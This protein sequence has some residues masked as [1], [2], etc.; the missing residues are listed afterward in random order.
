MNAKNPIIWADYPDPDVI[1]VDNTYYMVSTSMHMFPGGQILSSLDLVHWEHSCYVFDSL[2]D[3]QAQRL[4]GG[5]IYGKGMWA[6][7][8]RHHNGLFHLM[9]ACNDTHKSYRFTSEKA[10]GP[11]TRHEIQ[12]FYHDCSLLFDDDGRVYIAHGYKEIRITEL[13][14]DLSGPKEGGLQRVA[15]TDTGDVRVCFEGTHFYK[16]DGKYYLFCIHWPNDGYARRTEVCY[17]AD[18]LTSAFTGKTIVDDDL[19]FHNM[20]I[21][22]GALVDTPQGHWYLMLFQDHGAV[23]RSPVLVP[24]TWKNSFPSVANIPEQFAVDSPSLKHSHK[25]LHASDTLRKMPL[26]P[27]WQWNH[28]SHNSLWSVTENGLRMMTDRTVSCLEKAVNILTQRTF[29]PE[30]QATVTVDASQMH[31]GDYAGLCALQGC[32]CQ[33]AVTH[34]TDGLYL[35]FISREAASHN[36]FSST[37]PVCERVRIKHDQH[38]VK[39]KACFRFDD[40]ADSVSFFY[41][42]QECWLPVGKPHALVYRLDHFMGCRIGL[43]CYATKQPGGSAVFSDFEYMVSP[44]CLCPG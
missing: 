15:I 35:S 38:L 25:P 9:F 10:H 29:G 17:M 20:G 7:S 41:L 8:L 31:I 21:A 2:G 33:L 30:C 11:W 4:N 22:Q 13:E 12:G 5:D 42:N 26:S 27:Y 23:G 40:M 24:M 36:I 32:F 28:E 34:D 1:R 16:I 37:E 19:G 14:S 43:F 44:V 3:S 6:A 39:I 18:S